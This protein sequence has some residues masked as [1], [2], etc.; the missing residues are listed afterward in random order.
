MNIELLVVIVGTVLIFSTM[1]VIMLRFFNAGD[2]RHNLGR[3]V[4]DTYWDRINGS[5]D[6]HRR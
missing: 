6:D 5:D 1:G 3:S 2:D 4:G